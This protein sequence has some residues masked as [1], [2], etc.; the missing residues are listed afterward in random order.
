ML[1][2]AVIQLGFLISMQ[3]YPLNIQK[4]YSTYG[5]NLINDITIYTP[6][7][8]SFL[9]K[10]SGTSLMEDGVTLNS[11]SNPIND[12]KYLG[13]SIQLWLDK[14]YIPQDI[15]RKLGEEVSRVYIEK[16]NEGDYLTITC[17]YL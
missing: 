5:K 4:I 17:M 13:E 12:G 8:R 1:I 15:H 9:L 14:E 7:Q 16:R 2:Q 3:S 11:L 6:I 10:S